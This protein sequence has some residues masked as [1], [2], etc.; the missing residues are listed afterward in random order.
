VVDNTKLEGAWDFTLK[1]TSPGRLAAAGAEGITIFDAIDKQLGL[2]LEAKQ[3]P[4]PVLVVDRVNRKPTDNSPDVTASLPPAPSPHFEAATLK[5]TDPQLQAPVF[6]TP[7]NGEITIHGVTLSYLIQTIWFVTPER[8]VDAPK[9][10]DTD[11][12]DI[13]AK[14]SFGAGAHRYKFDDRDGSAEDSYGRAGG[15][16]V[17]TGCIKT[18]IAESGPCESYRV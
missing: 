14:T 9:W 15:A 7:P 6:Q 11:R 10:L 1:W 5:P 8:I 18:E 13:V 16:R 12:W 2:K 3:V 17:L 4:A